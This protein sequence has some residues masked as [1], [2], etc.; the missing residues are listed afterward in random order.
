M[1]DHECGLLELALAAAHDTDP[2]IVWQHVIALDHDTRKWLLL[3]GLRDPRHLIQLD[4]AWDTITEILKATQDTADVVLDVGQIGGSDTPINLIAA[5]DMAVMLVR[6]T[7]R[8][9]AQARPRLD[10]LER[11]VGSDLAVGLCVVGDGPYTLKE[12]SRALF[13]L[14]VLAWIPHDPKSA[15]VLSDGKRAKKS[16]HRSALMRGTVHLGYAMRHHHAKKA[17]PR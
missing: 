9:V 4:G 8:H 16:F 7:L 10:A 1:E 14:P 17:V 6:P 5:S 3:P 12:I 2:N 15:A 13:D 11:Q